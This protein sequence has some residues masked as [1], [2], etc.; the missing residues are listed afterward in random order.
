MR[1]V[2]P[3]FLTIFNSGTN[4]LNFCKKNSSSSP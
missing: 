2:K 1:Q 4:G 3:K